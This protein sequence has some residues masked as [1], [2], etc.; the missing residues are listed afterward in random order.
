[1]GVGDSCLPL[2]DSCAP[3]IRYPI[4]TRHLDS[5]PVSFGARQ[6][7]IIK[8]AR[9]R[10]GV[11]C[12]ALDRTLRVGAKRGDGEDVPGGVPIGGEL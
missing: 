10:S 4:M 1:M 12:W 5:W 7:G 11:G 3:C 8:N 2:P 6:L 9:V